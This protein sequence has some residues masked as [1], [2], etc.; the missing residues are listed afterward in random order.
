MD[1]EGEIAIFAQVDRDGLAADVVNHRLVNRKAGI[2]V[3]DLVSLINKGQDGKEYDRLAARNHDHFIAGYFHA[4][5]AADVVGERLPQFGQARGRAVMGPA[6]V[7]RVHTRFH[8]VRRSV[9]IRLAN[10]EV[11][12][13]LALALQRPGL[14]QDLKG[15]FG[16]QSR[17]AAG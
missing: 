1:V 12:H 17:H 15:G 2:G 13:A 4:T 7:Q 16:A 8:D 9:E 6:F 5:G 10:L 11:D 3:D 14:I